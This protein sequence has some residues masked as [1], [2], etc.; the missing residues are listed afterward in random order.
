MKYNIH[1]IVKYMTVC[2]LCPTVAR[3]GHIFGNVFARRSADLAIYRHPRSH[4]FDI[5]FWSELQRNSKL[6]KRGRD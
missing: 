1:M 4:I 6:S 5:K 3:V 2:P